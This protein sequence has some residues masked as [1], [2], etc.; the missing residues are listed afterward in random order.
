MGAHAGGAKGARGER[1]AGRSRLAA[2]M[3]MVGASR[4][5][6]SPADLDDIG[7]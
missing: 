2:K 4:N 1:R 6:H 5:L 7:I 3:P